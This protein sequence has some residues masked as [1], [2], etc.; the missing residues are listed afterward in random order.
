MKRPSGKK[1][2]RNRKPSPDLIR[3][4]IQQMGDEHRQAW[5]EELSAPAPYWS[6]LLALHLRLVELDHLEEA[7]EELL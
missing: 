2:A 4:Q 7:V 1:I 3:R 5:Q 6:R